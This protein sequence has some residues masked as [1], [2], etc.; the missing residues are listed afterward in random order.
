MREMR[1]KVTTPLSMC[2]SVQERKSKTLIV[3]SSEQVA[4]LASV[5]EKLIKREPQRH[6]KNDFMN[7][8][9]VLAHFINTSTNTHNL[10]ME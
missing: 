5:G 3:P 1:E 6:I 8:I 7:Y 10:N 4:S 2:S 9:Y